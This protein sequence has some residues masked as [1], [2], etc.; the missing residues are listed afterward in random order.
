MSK[1][2]K[3]FTLV[4]LVVVIA[5]V[6]ILASVSVGGY[7]IYINQAQKAEIKTFQNQMVTALKAMVTEQTVVVDGVTYKLIANRGGYIEVKEA[8]GQNIDKKFGPKILITY[9]NGNYADKDKIYSLDGKKVP[10]GTGYFTTSYEDASYKWRSNGTAYVEESKFHFAGIN[11][12]I[13][14]GK[15]MDYDY[16]SS[17]NTVTLQLIF[18]KVAVI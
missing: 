16:I 3:A 12:E 9:L 18:S 5:I 6:A 4:E 2:K 14:G 13:R 8:T 11:C 15:I 7:F 10:E 1:L 17:Y